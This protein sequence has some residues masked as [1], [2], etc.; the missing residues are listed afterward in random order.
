MTEQLE[1]LGVADLFSAILTTAEAGAPK[2]EPAVFRLALER[3]GVAPGRA[4]HVGDEPG[5]EEGARAAGMAFAPAPLA[6]AFAS[7]A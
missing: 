1:R 3:L 2:P 4:L 5:D 7:W 6:G